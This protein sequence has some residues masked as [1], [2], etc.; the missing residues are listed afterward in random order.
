MHGVEKVC[1]CVRGV[2]AAIEMLDLLKGSAA[3]GGVGEVGVWEGGE[4]IGAG[5]SRG[6]RREEVAEMHYVQQWWSVW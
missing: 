6:K 3:V 1:G 4:G 5:E 2:R